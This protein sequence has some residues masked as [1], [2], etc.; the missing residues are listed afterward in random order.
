[1]NATIQT[2]R[3]SPVRTLRAWLQGERA[4]RGAG[5]IA[6]DVAQRQV[7]R[8]QRLITRVSAGAEEIEHRVDRACAAVQE[9]LTDAV[10][11]G[12]IDRHEAPGVHRAVIGACLA[13]YEHKKTVG[14]LV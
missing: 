13:A 1:M 2:K 6:L 7:E 3:P 8:E 9:A 11:P 10:S 4:V 12:V 5:D 14:N